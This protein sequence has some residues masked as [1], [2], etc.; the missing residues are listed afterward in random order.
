MFWSVLPLMSG[1]ASFQRENPVASPATAP[2]PSV[3]LPI[4]PFPP[5]PPFTPSAVFR[6]AYVVVEADT[7]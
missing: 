3:E 7:R 4:A 6:N 2:D 1:L 5:P